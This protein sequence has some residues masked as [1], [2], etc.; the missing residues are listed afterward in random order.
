MFFAFA[1]FAW[2]DAIE[3][4]RY[5]V[6]LAAYL[7]VAVDELLKADLSQF[8]QATVYD[9]CWAA[10]LTN[11]DGSLAYPHL[12]QALMERQHP[13]GSWGSRAPYV[14]DRVLS[15]LAVL[16]LR[17]F[18]HRR[19]NREQ[20]LAGERYIWEHTGELEHDVH[21]TVGFE[22]ILPVLLDEGKELGLD[23]PYV[24]LRRYEA[25]RAE[26][27]KVLPLQ[28]LLE[29]RTTALF[30]LEAFP[31][32][33]DMDSASSVLLEDGSMAG[34]PSATAWFLGQVPDWRTHYPQSTAYLENLLR[35]YDSGLPAMAPCGIFARTWVL[36]YLYWGGLLAGRKDLL[37][38]HYQYLLDHW[39]LEGV[40]FSPFMFPDSDDTSMALL[41]LYRAGYDVDGT[42]LLAYER[43]EHFAVFNYELQPSISANLHILEAVDTLPKRDR[44]RVRDKIIDY[45]FAE[46]QPGGYWGDKW[47]GSVYYPTSQALM[48]LLPYAPDRM[49]KSVEWLLSNQR[50]DGSWGQYAPTVE[51]TALVLL[52][53]LLYR[54]AGWSLPKHHLRLAVRYLLSQEESSEKNYSELWT[55]KV[56]FA[57]ASIIRS[58]VLAAIGLYLDTFGG[59]G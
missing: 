34:S 21:P 59:L 44:P 42:P 18:G 55:A 13:D 56:L 11:E 31:G 39:H 50:A 36:Y 29:I 14:H 30:S 2:L 43:D 19:Y 32:Y 51:E 8:D 16:L 35:R 17:R 7:N 57:P 12:L 24:Q 38:S 20:W 41:A 3:G 9:T 25:E 33:G 49:A 28:R 40:G 45:V 37:R 48:A 47:H 6:R 27:L 5:S 23:L 15:T 52:P 4:G 1:S 10:R 22:M 54:R 26:K 46:R 58:M 53:L